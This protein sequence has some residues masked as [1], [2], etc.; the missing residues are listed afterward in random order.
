[1]NGK[2]E[3]WKNQRL[4]PGTAS[5]D[6]WQR[7]T[8][9]CKVLRQAILFGRELGVVFLAFRNVNPCNSPLVKILIKRYEEKVS[10]RKKGEGGSN[11]FESRISSLALW[12]EVFPCKSVLL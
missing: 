3:G 6:K 7:Q 11:E 4:L 9:I 8:A 2:G 10:K 12:N 5:D 1:M